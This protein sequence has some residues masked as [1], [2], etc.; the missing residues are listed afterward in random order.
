MQKFWKLSL[1]ILLI[2]S[3]FDFVTSNKESCSTIR[4]ETVPL[5]HQN[6]IYLDDLK[7][8][9]VASMVLLQNSCFALSMH[10]LTKIYTYYNKQT[11]ISFYF[12]WKTVT[13]ANCSILLTLPALIWDI[14]VY[15][16]HSYFIVSYAT[17]SQL[18]TYRGNNYFYT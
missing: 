12:I 5:Q 9:K 15:N 16:I 2:E 10:L 13:L 6:E 8:Y 7:F 14:N 1:I 3:Y 4:N 18:I 11:D 17:L